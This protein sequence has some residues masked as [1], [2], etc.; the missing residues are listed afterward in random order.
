MTPAP[1]PMPPFTI[2][3][4]QNHRPPTD[5]DEIASEIGKPSTLSTH[6]GAFA[7]GFTVGLIVLAALITTLT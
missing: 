6:F 1:S 4:M 2:I 3:P 7:L 5:I